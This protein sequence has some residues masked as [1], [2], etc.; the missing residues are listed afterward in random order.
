MIC[1]AILSICEIEDSAAVALLDVSG[2]RIYLRQSGSQ[3]NDDIHERLTDNFGTE[4]FLSSDMGDRL[5]R[6]DSRLQDLADEDI[7]VRKIMRTQSEERDMHPEV[8]SIRLADV[9][10]DSPFQFDASQSSDFTDGIC[11]ILSRVLKRSPS[12]F[13]KADCDST[14]EA[15]FRRTAPGANS[16]LVHPLWHPDG[17]PLKLMLLAWNHEPPR[18]DETQSFV[19]SIMTGLSAALTLHRARRMEKA[20]IAFG[21]VQAQC[22]PSGGQSVTSLMIFC[23]DSTASCELLSIKFGTWHHC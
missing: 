17:N 19:T 2:Y 21:N 22:V 20:Q 18:K 10:Y 12:W 5:S 9:A 13:S 6:L 23:S 15:I 3:L 1:Q 7:V 4:G 16:M 11:D 14:T 8:I